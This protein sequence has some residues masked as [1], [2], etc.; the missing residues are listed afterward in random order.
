MRT[1]QLEEDKK[2]KIKNKSQN[3]WK[4]QTNKHIKGN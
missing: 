4:V 1:P 2:I 3:Q